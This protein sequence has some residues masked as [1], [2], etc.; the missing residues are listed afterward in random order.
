MVRRM[1]SSGIVAAPATAMGR[2]RGDLADLGSAVR[3]LKNPTADGRAER[4]ADAD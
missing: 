3:F 2:A 4:P 1:V